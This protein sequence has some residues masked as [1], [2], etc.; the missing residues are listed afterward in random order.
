MKRYGCPHILVTDKLRSYRAAMQVD[1]KQEAGA[2]IA[3]RMHIC[4]FNDESGRCS[5]SGRC[6]VFRN[7][8]PFIL[9]STT[10]SPKTATSTHAIISNS[11]E[12]PHSL[13]CVSFVPGKFTTAAAN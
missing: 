12:P 4:R 9:P 5:V 2:T 11:T 8:H 6:D 7:S 3:F 1:R 10:V 13:S